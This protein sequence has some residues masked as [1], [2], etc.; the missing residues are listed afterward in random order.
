MTGIELIAAANALIALAQ[1]VIVEKR[2]A[3][4]AEVDASFA[5]RNDAKIQAHAALE[6]AR[7]REAG[8]N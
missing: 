5:E 6:R 4:E 7:L 8:D 3:T 2:E 1:K